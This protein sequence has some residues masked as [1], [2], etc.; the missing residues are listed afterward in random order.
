MP[1]KQY[2]RFT[3][4]MNP[5]DPSAVLNAKQVDAAIRQVV[6]QLQ[7]E[8]EKVHRSE[9]YTRG[10][11]VNADYYVP[12]G[13]AQMA[14]NAAAE[15][16]ERMKNPSGLSFSSASPATMA[17]WTGTI[18]DPRARAQVAR[19]VD[20]S[21]GMFTTNDQGISSYMI[22]KART[23]RGSNG[24]FVN[25][26][27]HIARMIHSAN[28][29]HV[30]G[31]E[32][33]MSQ[34]NVHAGYND[35]DDVE[36][37]AMAGAASSVKA[38]RAKRMVS[39][40]NERE[41][42][43]ARLESRKRRAEHE[44]QYE[45]DN[46][47]D[48]FVKRRRQA[49]KMTARAK[50]QKAVGGAGKFMS[51]AILGTI[52]GIL[53]F[54]GLSV[55]IL[56][57]IRDALL[58]IG[59]KVREQNMGAAAYNFSVDTVQ[60]WERFAAKRG[61]NKEE[62]AQTAG[63]FMEKFGNPIW[64]QSSS[65]EKIAPFIKEDTTVLTGLAREGGDKNVLKMIGLVMGS[66]AKR[67]RAGEAGG[68]HGLDVG[69]AY[70]ENL[71]AVRD[72]F[73]DATAQHFANY[74]YDTKGKVDYAT[75]SSGGMSPEYAVGDVVKNKA[76]RKAAEE[77]H[78]SVGNFVG[79]YGAAAEDILRVIAG[80][81]D[82]LVELVRGI[83]SGLIERFFP[84][85][86]LQERK[87]NAYKNVTS[88]RLADAATPALE[89][90]ANGVLRGLGISMSASDTMAAISA[91]GKGLTDEQLAALRD[92]PDKLLAIANAAEVQEA[93]TKIAEYVKGGNKR[94]WNYTPAGAANS[95]GMAAWT[96]YLAIEDAL[97]E[98]GTGVVLPG[99]GMLAPGALKAMANPEM[100]KAATSEVK[101]TLASKMN[102][103]KNGVSGDPSSVIQ[104]AQNDLN[105]LLYYYAAAP[106]H[107]ADVEDILSQ[108]G[109]FQDEY[110]GNVEHVS[111]N[112]VTR[113]DLDKTK[114]NKVKS[115][116]V[117][118][119]KMLQGFSIKSL[120]SRAGA[121][122][123]VDSGADK[124]YETLSKLLTDPSSG[125]SSI[126]LPPVTS[127]Y[128]GAGIKPAQAGGQGD[129]GNVILHQI[130]D[131][132]EKT[133]TVPLER[134][135]SGDRVGNVGSTDTRWA[136]YINSATNKQSH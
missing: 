32:S 64:Y 56:N 127:V 129:A 53:T 135:P 121:W 88:K 52:T 84:E 102:I 124:T 91:G 5:K 21:G 73:G 60:G 7:K 3:F 2:E 22:D 42:T 31:W 1:N 105:M 123:A 10:G 69:Q 132:K 68:K 48:P 28:K 110:G 131:G 12:A 117:A 126:L 82:N 45:I 4:S 87:R 130:I 23:A 111:R 41:E 61:Y 35:Y 30:E 101:K 37:G 11:Q 103:L 71:Q 44:M 96:S 89:K 76:S 128:A 55:G 67:T 33:L 19:L 51:R 108:I 6:S 58:D 17:S 26:D 78:D 66:I 15:A 63:S 79:S 36:R 59:G 39:V 136:D 133:S 57:R 14:L 77:T 120:E 34:A 109:S 8:G 80:S 72:T 125:V 112:G 9:R 95:A 54:V 116:A 97:A 85:L 99:G 83:S 86:A 50:R 93:N 38:R 90:E 75:W 62:L 100:L 94:S 25:A 104:G 46:P 18:L 114:Q 113:R 43:Y 20:R 49:R 24:Q 74:W 65:F 92:D 119:V 27:A 40:A 16:L 107:E 70:S 13:T 106:G 47:N 118:A 122:E 98:R 29:Q 81:L 134:T 115:D